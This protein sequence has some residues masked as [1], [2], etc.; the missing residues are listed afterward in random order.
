MM[1]G[2]LVVVLDSNALHSDPWLTSPPGQK[3]R[4]IAAK[5]SCVVAYP[6]VVVDE[7]H[8]QRRESAVKAHQQ[9][10][11]SV[12]DMA[13]AGVDVMETRAQ[14]EASFT[15]ITADLDAAFEALFAQENIIVAPVPDVSV[16]ALLDRDL[17]R[18]RPFLEIERGEKYVSAGFRD[19]LIWETVLALLDP[20]G[21]YD[22]VLFVTA[23][24]GF[25]DDAATGLHQ[26]LRA[27]LDGRGVAFDRVSTVKN[28]AN[29]HASVA[30]AALTATRITAATNAL[31]ELVDQDISMQ[32]VYGGDYDYPDFVKFEVPPMESAMISYIDQVGGFTLEPGPD[33]DVVV[34]TAD[35][36]LSLEGVVFK[37]DWFVDGGE[38]VQIFGE[39]NDHYFEG[40]SEVTVRAVVELDIS[41]ETPEVLSIR[42]E[43]Q[44]Q[45]S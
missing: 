14:L 44:S 30:E 28:T 25:L 42:L 19:V 43:D 4:D 5:N 39:R 3:L 37:G 40:S 31:Y 24:K 38:S 9:A 1:G 6:Q 11:K 41:A 26:H 22:S 15:R 35:V 36:V 21:E 34:A 27:D 33:S 32:M 20:Q 45:A 12:T 13:K 29:A 16:A 7:L 18:R 17:A 23:D 10:A 2:M 8:R